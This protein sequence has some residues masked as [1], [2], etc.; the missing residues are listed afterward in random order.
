MTVAGIS[1]SLPEKIISELDTRRGLVSR[2][3]YVNRLLQ[4]SLS[5]DSRKGTT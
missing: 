3:K 5:N 1:I 4:A 2:S